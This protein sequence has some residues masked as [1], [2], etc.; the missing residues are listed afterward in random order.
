[1]SF[2]FSPKIVIDGLVLY[3]DAANPISYVSGSTTW[4]DIS[5][6]GNNGTLT[7]GPTFN[8]ANRGSIYFDG[9][10]DYV[11]CGPST[12]AMSNVFT[13]CFWASPIEINGGSL[14]GNSKEGGGVH[15]FM[16]FSNLYLVKQNIIIMGSCSTSSALPNWNYYCIS[17]S[18][19]NITFFI[20]GNLI[21][22]GTFATTFDFTNS[23]VWIGSRAS[24]G[25][26]YQPYRGRISS[27][28]LYN[29]ILTSQQI[30]QNYNAIKGRYGL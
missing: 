19:P 24:F 10:N 1:M 29:K 13:Y 27:V 21:T 14:L 20:N 7:N 23:D 17:Y 8:S 15:I 4:N 3:L 18:S 30:L 9:T 22:T 11:N 12:N 6:G 16:D 2:N 25:T 26:P 5:R 28:Q